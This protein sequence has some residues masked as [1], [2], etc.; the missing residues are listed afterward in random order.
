MAGGTILIEDFIDISKFD[1]G[2]CLC[3]ER[4]MFCSTTVTAA[5][6]T[7]NVDAAA[8]GT[9]IIDTSSNN[10]TIGG[11]INGVAKQTMFIVV[12]DS[13]N[14]AV[15]EHNEGTGNQDI[16]LNSGGDDTLTASYGGWLLI[17]DGSN[18]YEVGKKSKAAGYVSRGDDSS[19]DFDQTDL[20]VNATWTDI[21]LSSIVPVGAI[22]V[23][24]YVEYE[25][26]STGLAMYFRKKGA[27]GGTKNRG[28]L[29]NQVANV[30]VADDPIVSCDSNRE[31]QYWHSTAAF[32]HIGVFVKGWFI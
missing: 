27:A 19:Y 12:T 14:N 5:G 13:T 22:A 18:W 1:A 11:F 16:F 3:P 23:H 4:Q 10:V 9:V 24:L 15:L 8:I 32:D 31:I 28:G 2:A 6:P 21:D 30:I 7:D 29:Y 17:C 25:D 26:N 20:S